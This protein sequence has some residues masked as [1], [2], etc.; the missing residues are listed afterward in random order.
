MA[1]TTGWSAPGS[2]VSRLSSLKGRAVASAGNL[3]LDLSKPDTAWFIEKGAVDLFLVELKDGVEQAAPQHLLRAEAGRLIPG[4]AAQTEDTTLKVIAKGLPGAKLRAIALAH[5]SAAPHAE[6]AANI[7]AWLIDLSAVLS[8][9]VEYRPR[10]DRLIE[11]GPAI[12]AGAGIHSSRKGVVWVSV[13]MPGAS[14]YL[15][16][17]DPAEN[18]EDSAGLLP[19]TPATWLDVNR[20]AELSVYRSEDLAGNGTLLAA[21]NG[22]HAL[23]L[24]LERL[25]RSLAV[26]DQANL[27]RAR[28]SNR[29]NDEET[30]R[31]RLFNLYG[32]LKRESDKTGDVAMRRVLEL[33]GRHEGISF[34]QPPPSETFDRRLFLRELLD[35]SGVRGRRVALRLADQWWSGD[36]GAILAFRSKDESPVALLP[37]VLGRYREVDPATGRRFRVTPKRA[38]QLDTE[39]WM[40]Y[41]PLPAR[42]V[43]MRDLL[44]IARRGLAA[45]LL[46]FLTVGMLGGLLMLLPAV[47]VGFIADRIIPAEDTGLLYLATIALAAFAVAGALVHILQNMALMRLEGRAASRIEAAF[48]DRLLRL[49][50]GFL[51]RYSTGDLAMRGMTFQN[52][53]DAVQGVV[54]NSVLSVLFLS[55]AVVVV[56]LYDSMLGT[57]VT[58][59]GVLALAATVIVGSRQMKPTARMIESVQR[60]VGQLYQLVKGIAKLRIDGAEGSAFAVWAS[61]YRKQKQAESQLGRMEEHL[62]AFGAALPLLTAALLFLAVAL[63]GGGDLS[64]GDFLVIY[65]LFVL[66]QSAVVRLGRSFGAIAAVSPSLN[67]IRP[68]LAEPREKAAEGERVGR[69]SGNMVFDRVSFRYDPEGPLILDEVSVRAQPGEFVAIAGESGAGKSTLLKLALGLKHPASGAVYLDGKDLKHLNLKQLR[70]KIG[71]VPQEVTLHPE[72]LWDNIVGDSEH[73]GPEDAW[74]AVEEA[75][76]H[77]EIAAMPMGMMTFVGAGAGSMSGGES[78]RVMIARALIRKPGILLLDEATNWLDNESQAIVMRNLAR[79]SATRIVIAHRLSTLRLA[80]RIY[81]MQSGRVVEQGSFDELMETDGVFRDLVRRQIA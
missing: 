18:L 34:K 74:K 67:Q 27:E 2:A 24:T 64:V 73:L 63:P 11:P 42:G 61:N 80:D 54:A 17:A 13:A 55:P 72:D 35:S 45:N 44:E 40:F 56:F 16:L 57:V 6:L 23:A 8:R 21:L 51:Q 52:L 14:L 53:R 19:L 32:L 25:N 31:R 50:S 10:F 29:R 75:H 77:E 71:V 81:V 9:D 41:K 20:D 68:F 46:R 30:A 22:F 43:G 49:P 12:P 1:F 28:A 33:I 79:F 76:V 38:A 58:V 37:G 59:F 39:A 66:F 7:D 48:W 3:P 36:N 26:V 62:Q 70:R 65:T 60:L 5:L 4:V 69:V 78:Q 47:V 15:G